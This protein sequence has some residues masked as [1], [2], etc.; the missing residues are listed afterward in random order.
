MSNNIEKFVAA[1]V[2][3][4]QTVADAFNQLLTECDLETAVGVQLDQLGKLVGRAREGVTDDDVYRRLIAAQITV[5]KS[6]GSIET[7][8]KIAGFLVLDDDAVFILDNHGDAAFT[9]KVEGTAVDAVTQAFL[10][11]LLK[12]AVSAGVRIVTE[13]WTDADADELFAWEGV[14]PSG[15]PGKGHGDMIPSYD[16]IGMT[17]DWNV[18]GSVGI[19]SVETLIGDGYLEFSAI[20]DGNWF[21]IGL[22]PDD[23]TT[24]YAEPGIYALLLRQDGADDFDARYSAGVESMAGV[25]PGPWLTSDLW[26]IQRIGSTVTLHRNGS[27]IYTWTTPS[28]GPLRVDATALATDGTIERVRFVS[29]GQRERITWQ[30]IVN[31]TPVARTDD[32]EIG[33]IGGKL[34]SAT[35]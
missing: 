21:Q 6:S 15:T 5:N 29:S 9:Y 24:T 26:R 10:I 7:M 11:K 3:P 35:E 16:L 30:N 1:L 27:V 33:S 14:T 4:T 18:E 12:Q 25:F 19:S 32:Y 34:I 23:T 31:V 8:H 17:G 13:F 22:A 20:N 2:A 28:T